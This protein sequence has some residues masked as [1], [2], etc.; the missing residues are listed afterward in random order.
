MYKENSNYSW[1]PLGYPPQIMI[2]Y[3]PLCRSLNHLK[4]TLSEVDCIS[5]VVKNNNNTRKLNN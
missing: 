3:G 2:F 5:Y 1:Q 4:T